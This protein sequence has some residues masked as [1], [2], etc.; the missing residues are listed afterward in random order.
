[1]APRKLSKQSTFNSVASS[2]TTSSTTQIPSI[3]TDGQPLPTVVVFDLDYT[4]WPFWV[5]THVSGS[6]LEPND[7]ASACTDKN[8]E[9]FALY[10]DIPSV[11]HGLSLS[12]IKLGVASRTTRDDLAKKMLNTLYIPP[13]S[14]KDGK[15]KKA[16][17]FFTEVGLEMY[18]GTKIRHFQALQKRTGVAY[19]EML[20]FDDEPDNRDVETLGVTMRLVRDG[21]T[22]HEVEEGIKEWRR[23]RRL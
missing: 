18:P 9:S 21:V 20:F 7:S 10:P 6:K 2:S 1:M 11:L 4:L 15:K 23:R 16:W 12:G 5:D 14:K 13:A 22:W 8:G 19:P 3:L 17:E